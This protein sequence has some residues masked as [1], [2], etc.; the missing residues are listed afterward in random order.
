MTFHL[1]EKSTIC[2]ALIKNN[3]GVYYL[4]SKES[5]PSPFEKVTIFTLVAAICRGILTIDRYTQE[6]IRQRFYNFKL[7]IDGIRHR[8]RDCWDCRLIY[9]ICIID[10][11]ISSVV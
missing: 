10:E 11:L 4:V 5:F 1:T 2:V 8:S 7:T 9:G 6:L 3:A